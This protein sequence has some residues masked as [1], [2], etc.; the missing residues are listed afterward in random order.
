MSMENGDLLE[1]IDEKFREYDRCRREKEEAA[2]R[3]CNCDKRLRDCLEL[4]YSQVT[5]DSLFN[6]G[7]RRRRL[8]TFKTDS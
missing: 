2:K 6:A 4:Y 7:N 8:K 1:S 5:G 3:L